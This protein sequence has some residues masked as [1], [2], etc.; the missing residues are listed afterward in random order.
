M[1]SN[2]VATAAHKLSKGNAQLALQLIGYDQDLTTAMQY[3]FGSTFV[4][5]V[6]SP[7]LESRVTSG[8]KMNKGQDSMTC[9]QTN[10]RLHVSIYRHRCTRLL[11]MHLLSLL[12]AAY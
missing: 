12:L 1:A 7:S 11:G 4:C 3:V 6:F 10:D 9:P 5:K 8:K 2:A